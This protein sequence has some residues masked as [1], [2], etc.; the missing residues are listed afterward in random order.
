M[1]CSYTNDFYFPSK[2]GGH[3]IEAKPVM[4]SKSKWNFP[5]FIMSLSSTKLPSFINQL[6]TD[7]WNVV[8][9]ALA[10]PSFIIF[11]LLR[12]IL[13]HDM[14]HPTPFGLNRN[15]WSW[16]STTWYFRVPLPPN[17]FPMDFLIKELWKFFAYHKNYLWPPSVSWDRAIDWLK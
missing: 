15:L 6:P 13:T 8:N 5:Q 9:A 16:N 7:T 14:A 12:P 10:I 1:L 17:C 4:R 11:F 3:P 2:I